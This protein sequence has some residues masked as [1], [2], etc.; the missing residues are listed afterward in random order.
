MAACVGVRPTSGEQCSRPHGGRRA[1]LRAGRG[2]RAG[3]RPPPCLGARAPA[4][5]AV[6]TPIAGPGPQAVADACLLE[7]ATT[8][9]AGSRGSR[10]V[11]DPA[12]PAS[13]PIAASGLDF[14]GRP[15]TEPS[16][17]GWVPAA[18]VFFNDPDGHLLEYLAM[19]PH[20]PRPQAGVVPHKE[21]MAEWARTAA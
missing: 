5:A 4:A 19:L 6:E 12:A 3:R 2:S 8:S 20:E 15:T 7:P 1:R 17:I 14:Y 13:R 18:S 21:W 16:V 9:R 11:R 10:P